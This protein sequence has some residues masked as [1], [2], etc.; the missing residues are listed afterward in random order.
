MHSLTAKSYSEENFFITAISA[1][2][3]K[4]EISFQL[5]KWKIKY[6][7]FPSCH[8]LLETQAFHATSYYRMVTVFLNPVNEQRY[9]NNTAIPKGMLENI[10]R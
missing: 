8:Y 9:V 3:K 5:D 6:K 7:I 2:C 1:I 10:W 4:F